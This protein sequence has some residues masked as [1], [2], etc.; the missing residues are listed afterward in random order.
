MN[1]HS[2][3]PDEAVGIRAGDFYARRC[4]DALGLTAQN[5]V[6]RA[7][8]VHYNTSDEVDRLIRGLDEVI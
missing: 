7:S 3:P 2:K 4:I 8:M 1:S 5:G 6:V